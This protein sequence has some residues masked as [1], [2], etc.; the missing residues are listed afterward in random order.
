LSTSL[1]TA[2]AASLLPL[3]LLLALT[4][5]LQ[6]QDR[7]KATTKSAAVLPAPPAEAQAQYN[8]ATNNGAITITKCSDS[9]GAVTIPSTINGLPV[10][11]IGDSAFAY[12]ATLTNVTIPNSISNIGNSAF[13]G[14]PGLTSVTIP[15]SVTNIGDYVFESCPSLAAIA[16]DALNL[17]Y[18]SVDGVL[19]NK[20][21]TRLVQCPGGKAGSY[22]IPDSVIHLEPYAFSGCSSLTS[23]TIGNRVTHIGAWAFKSCTVLT[24]VTIPDSV[25]GIGEGAFWSC[26]GLASVTIPS[27]V[28][29][30][31]SCACSFCSGLTSVYFKGNAPDIGLDVFNGDNNTV[32]VYYLPGTT[33][34]GS[35]FAGRAAVLWK[36]QV[37]AS[38]TGLGAPTS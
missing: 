37:N 38:R 35:T 16:V 22:T 15:N 21:Q 19:F 25:T 4:V 36:P 20:S 29:S 24:N 28:I 27:S 23:V 7:V 11:S 17:F 32:V 31:G 1:R 12:C 33:G 13:A 5:A 10:T 14:C 2:L 3:L 6:A 8:C 34:W 30:I 26:A 9:R 18:S